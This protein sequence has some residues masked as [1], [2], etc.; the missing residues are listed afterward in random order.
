M[1]DAQKVASDYVR[2]Q[3]RKEMLAV[4]GMDRMTENSDEKGREKEMAAQAEQ[5]LLDGAADSNGA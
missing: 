2:D 5:S 3:A 4:K 1:S